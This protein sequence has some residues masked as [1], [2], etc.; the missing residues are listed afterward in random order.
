MD[1]ADDR[2]RLSP[3]QTLLISWQHFAEHRN[4]TCPRMAQGPQHSLRRR[5]SHQILSAIG[6]TKAHARSSARRNMGMFSSSF[7]R[8]L[9]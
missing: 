2:D 7:E 1:D 9:V 8:L 3:V 5:T 4:W 6:F